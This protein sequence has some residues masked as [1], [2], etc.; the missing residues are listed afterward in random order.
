MDT[1]QKFK[2]YCSNLEKQFPLNDGS[3]DLIL[4]AIAS[5]S[6][7]DEEGDMITNEC[8]ESMKNQALGLNIHLDHNHDTHNVIGNVIEVLET[9][10]KTLK[11]KF[12]ILPSW[13]SKILEYLDNGIALGLSIGV[14]VKDFEETDSGWEIKDIKLYE[15]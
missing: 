4:E 13:Q 15:I 7:I 14:A 9:D 8:I 11:I 2:V 6:S 12:K 10:N 1:K 5:T 3:D